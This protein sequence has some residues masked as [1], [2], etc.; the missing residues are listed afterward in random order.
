MI[1]VVGVATLARRGW[2]A[3]AFQVLPLA[4]LHTLWRV[5]TNPGGIDNPYGR[6]P[7]VSE[8]FRFV[9]SGLRGTF[10][11]VG[12]FAAIGVFLALVLF[13]G[14]WLSWKDSRAHSRLVAPAALLGGALVFLVGTSLTRW[15]VTPTADSQSRYLYILAALLLPGLGV[16]VDAVVRRWRVLIPLVLGVL[17]VAMVR[18][19]TDFGR[20]P[21]NTAYFRDQKQLVL[22]MAHSPTASRVPA[23]VRPNPWFSIGW[24]R[25]AAADGDVPKPGPVTPALA[26]RI[27]F[28]LTIAQLDG[29]YSMGQC[30]TYANGAVLRPAKGERFGI[31]FGA[32][33]AEGANFFQQNAV[34]VSLLDANRQPLATSIFKT[35]FGRVL[36]IEFAR[37]RLRISTADE[38]QPLVLCRRV[39]DRG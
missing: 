32:R 35:E 7:T 33:P 14:A 16:A 24:L 1:A 34:V 10:V 26:R 17:L 23:Y 29:R 30:R 39:S 15:F 19:A 20:A 18:N 12:G 25:D 28:Q 5:A 6:N 4:A 21:F 38:H 27:E 37:T 31:R 8:V 11:A 36:E 9:W 13:V 3:A 2:K 22:A